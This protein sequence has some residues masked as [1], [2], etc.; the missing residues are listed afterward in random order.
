MATWPSRH[1]TTWNSE[2]LPSRPGELPDASAP[3]AA[4]QFTHCSTSASETRT[5]GGFWLASRAASAAAR[6]VKAVRPAA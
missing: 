1:G 6:P 3:D 2:F 4:F 5:E